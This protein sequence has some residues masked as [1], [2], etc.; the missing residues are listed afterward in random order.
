[1][2]SNRHLDLINEL[3]IFSFVV[4]ESKSDFCLK[5]EHF[6]STKLSIETFVVLRLHNG[7]VQSL[8]YYNNQS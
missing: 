3:S 8:E 1:M 6:S 5:I 2:N 4:S 7:Y